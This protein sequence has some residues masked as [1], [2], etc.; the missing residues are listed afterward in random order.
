[1]EF[2]KFVRLGLVNNNGGGQLSVR[3]E[4]GWRG[5]ACMFA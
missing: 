1:M 5:F 3:L 4:V 2:R